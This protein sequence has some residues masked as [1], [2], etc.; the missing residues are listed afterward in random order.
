LRQQAREGNMKAA[1]ILHQVDRSVTFFPEGPFRTPAI[2]SAPNA[3]V[4]NNSDYMLRRAPNT[5]Y[6]VYR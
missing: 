5:T 1:E 4:L 6:H 2:I 3:Y